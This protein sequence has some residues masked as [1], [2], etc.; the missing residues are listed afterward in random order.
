MKKITLRNTG[1]ILTMFLFTTSA[2]TQ[3]YMI[4]SKNKGRRHNGFYFSYSGGA[5]NSNVRIDDNYGFS[6]VKGIG[7]LMDMKIGWSIVEDIILHVTWLNH[8][9]SEPYVQ[10]NNN[11][12]YV[13]EHIELSELMLGGGITYYNSMNFLLSTSVGFGGYHLTNEN[14]N[15]GISSEGGF[16]F[17]IKAGK[18][19]WVSRRLALGV[20]AYYHKTY[21]HNNPNSNVNERLNSNNLG[22]VL[23]IT[24]SGKK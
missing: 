21:V 22:V 16:C 14:T 19:W 23:S 15:E 4:S 8:G 7:G 12:E 17:Q 13:S 2:F 20:A 1:L 5:Y 9:I 24:L 6:K 18:E 10:D 3:D 11:S